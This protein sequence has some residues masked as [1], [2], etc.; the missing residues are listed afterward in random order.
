VTALLVIAALVHS[1]PVGV[2]LR[3]YRLSPYRDVVRPGIVKFNLTNFGE[4]PHDLVVR[5]LSGRIVARVP[6][7]APGARRTARIRFRR[8]GRFVLFCS[9][10]DH[11]GRGMHARLKVSRHAR[12]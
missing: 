11:D 6:E 2:G 10:A 7:V 3:E 8:A 12:P 4:D 5:T 9:V 1:T